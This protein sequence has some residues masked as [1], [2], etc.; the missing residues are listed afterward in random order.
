MDKNFLTQVF[1]NN[2]GYTYEYTG[3]IP[4]GK[5]LAQH[6]TGEFVAAC[7]NNLISTMV[8]QFPYK[9]NRIVLYA[10]TDIDDNKSDKFQLITDLIPDPI[11]EIQEVTE[12]VT[13]EVTSE[14]EGI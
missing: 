3:T 9:N 14:S 11:V 8:V 13:E 6:V 7:G 1:N 4:E 12:E 5:Q 10:N 2:K